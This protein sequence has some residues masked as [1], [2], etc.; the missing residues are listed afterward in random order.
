MPSGHLHQLWL[1]IAHVSLGDPAK[2]ASRKSGAR[3]LDAIDIGLAT[4]WLHRIPRQ[5]RCAR[6]RIAMKP[7][8]RIGS[9]RWWV[10]ALSGLSAFLVIYVLLRLRAQSL[11]RSPFGGDSL[12][13]LNS[14][15]N[16]HV[17]RPEHPETWPYRVF[18]SSPWMPPNISVTVNRPGLAD[19][20]LFMT[21]KGRGGDDGI[22]QSAPFVMTSDNELVYAYNESHGTNGLRVQ[23]IAGKPHLTFWQG[24]T[25]IGRGYGQIILLDEQYHE[26][27]V[28]LHASINWVLGG[29]C[30]APGLID[31]HEHVV[32]PQGTILV[33][34]YNNTPTD[35]RAADGPEDGWAMDSLFYEIDIA[36]RETLFSW[37]ALDHIPIATS[38]LPV[39]SYM[40][41]GTMSRAWDFF[42]INSIQKLGDNFL[43]NSR[44]MWACYLISGQDGHI[45][46]KLSGSGDG[47]HFGP[48]PEHG[49]FRWQ[50]DARAHNVTEKSMAI[51]VFDN[52]NMVQDNGTM[53]T[54][55]LLLEVALP[56]DAARP[57]V[58]LRDLQD[59][60][61]FYSGS[62]GSYDAALSNGNQLMCYG[63]SPVVRE[64]GPA[65]DGS[66][67][68]WEGRVGLDDKVQTYRAFKAEWHATPQGWNP[69]LVIEA[70]GGGGGGGGE[71]QLLRGYVSW[72]GA[73]DVEAWV[74]YIGRPGG[75]M[76]KAG[77]A[78]KKGFETV[79]QV[80]AGKGACVKVA[81]E[82]GREEVRDS[83]VVC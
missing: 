14:S 21:P 37:S 51:S 30:E 2:W 69:S 15:A 64:Y 18:K 4:N 70:D 35:L 53:P 10:S 36:T 75:E 50:H 65:H 68:L 57:P 27:V 44:H 49:T 5:Q 59:S 39:Q 42:H 25:T 63:P 79:F 77:R 76:H 73:T 7:T 54:R 62:Q 55:G 60:N 33:T 38:H 11:T 81:A 29:D 61:R 74:V 66:D 32:T 20:Y 17:V 6:M 47:G 12:P 28:D 22:Q 52:H 23:E 56:P 13:L 43:I 72:N 82:R 67:L 1:T 41:D 26:T 80:R 8:Y 16:V 83:N 3:P 24:E 71:D 34:A 45:I 9:P 46:W 58:V 31:Y 48:V 40:G 78:M 19:G